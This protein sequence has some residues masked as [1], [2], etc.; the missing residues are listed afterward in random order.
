MFCAVTVAIFYIYAG[1]FKYNIK[2]GIS[3]GKLQWPQP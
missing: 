2:K 3:K 1:V